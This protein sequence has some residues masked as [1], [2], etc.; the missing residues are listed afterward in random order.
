[1]GDSDGSPVKTGGDPFQAVVSGP[2]DVGQVPLTDNGDGTWD[3][4]YT[5]QQPGHY[6]VEVTVNGEQVA[7]SPYKVL[8]QGA[9]P[10]ESWAEGPGLEGGQQGREGVFTIHG[11]GPD[12]TALKEGGDPFQV[13]ISGPEDIEAPVQDNGNGT[14]EVRYT[15]ERYGDYS[16]DVTLFDESI[17]D[18]P[19]T[20][21]IKPKPDAS[22]CWAEGPGLVEAWDNEPAS[23]TIHAV[24]ED[25]NP[26]TDGGDLFDVSIS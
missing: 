4:S 14:Y 17:K 18:S 16:I 24:D 6:T 9:A 26:R 5:V 23:F 21:A 25:G 8:I 7:E 11:V 1:M 20:V 3:G 22:Q 12:G 15:P 2:E 19:F 10:G 13:K